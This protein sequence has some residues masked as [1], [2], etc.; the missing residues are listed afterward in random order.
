MAIE[1]LDDITTHEACLVRWSAGRLDI[2][3]GYTSGN[4]IEPVDAEVRAIHV[5]GDTRNISDAAFSQ[6]AQGATDDEQGGNDDEYP[7]HP[8]ELATFLLWMDPICLIHN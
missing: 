4:F 3:E 7:S 2:I 5:D 6:S 8:T 1:R